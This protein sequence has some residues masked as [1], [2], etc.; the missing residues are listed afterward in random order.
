MSEIPLTADGVPFEIGMKLYTGVSWTY[1]GPFVTEKDT[2]GCIVL[3]DKLGGELVFFLGRKGS[4][5]TTDLRLLYSSPEASARKEIEVS[6]Q[7]IRDI[8]QE[9]SMLLKGVVVR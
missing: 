3:S 1:N 7:A 6:L 8:T 4:G 2:A 5:A 9:I